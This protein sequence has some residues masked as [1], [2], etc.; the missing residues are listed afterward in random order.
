MTLPLLYNQSHSL[1]TIEKKF[2]YL[3]PSGSFYTYH[4][5]SPCCSLNNQAH[6]YSNAFSLLFPLS[7]IFF[8]QISPLLTGKFHSG[9]CTNVILLKKS[10]LTMLVQSS[11]CH[12]SKDPAFIFFIASVTQLICY[13]S[14]PTNAGKATCKLHKRWKAPLF[15]AL[16]P[17]LKRALGTAQ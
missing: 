3:S 12:L 13:L 14:S 7:G 8:P 15:S 1:S 4:M 10:F 5:A 6:Y 9:L 17:G 2:I 11:I 16:S